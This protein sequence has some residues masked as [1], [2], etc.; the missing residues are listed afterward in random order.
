[1]KKFRD[2]FSKSIGLLLNI[3]LFITAAFFLN[4]KA[5]IFDLKPSPSPLAQTGTSNGQDVLGRYSQEPEIYIYGSDQQYA[6]GGIIPI[7]STDEPAV[8]IG[9]YNISGTA[10]V[11]LYKA[12]TDTLLS[13][14]IHDDKGNQLN[15]SVD[16]N[17]LEFITKVSQELS[18][19]TSSNKV[20]LPLS[21]TGIWYLD[22]TVGSTKVSAFVTRS[23]L[24]VITDEGDNQ[25]VFWGQNY[26]TKRS[27]DSGTISLINLKSGVSIIETTSFDGSGIGY[28]AV[29]ENA[30]IALI[31]QNDDYA[32]IPLNLRYLNYGYTYKAFRISQ[33]ESKYFIFTDRP[34]Y[35]PGDTVYFKAILR[36]DDDARYTIPSG[37]AQVEIYGEYY[38]S[39]SE[40]TPL[41]RNSYPISADGTI[42]GEYKIPTGSKVGYYTIKVDIGDSVYSYESSA[43]FDV[44]YYQKPEYFVEVNSD[45]SDVIA[46]DKIKFTISGSYFSG[47]P[48]TGQKVTYKI[49]S[50]SIFE[51]TYIDDAQHF[52]K[53]DNYYRYGYSSGENDIAEGT[54]TLNKYGVAEVIIDSNVDSNDG[55]SQVFSIE[56]TLSNRGIAPSFAR[57]NV[58]VRSGEY[59][60][61]R[62]ETNYRSKINESYSLPVTIS[63]NDEGAKI[64]GVK[65]SAKIHRENWIRVD[66]PNKKYP[67]YQ[68]EEEDLPDI[69]TKTNDSGVAT[70]SFTPTKVGSYSVTVLGNDSRGNTISKN[71]YLWVTAEDYAYTVNSNETGITLSRDKENYLPG[72]VLRL[73]IYSTIPDR[74]IFLALERGRVQRF[75]IVRLNGKTGTADIPLVETDMPNVYAVAY[76]FS[77]YALDS[78]SVN[79]PVSPNSKRIFVSLV[80]NAE[81]YGPGDTAT[82]EISTK[83]YEGNPISADVAL[84]AVDKAIFE[85]E[86]SNLGD[87]F[88]KFWQER[89][90]STHMAHSLEPITTDQSE[91]GGCFASGT[92]ILM[93]NSQVKDI[94]RVKVGD[95]VLTKDEKNNNL[96]KAKVVGTHSAI[97]DGYLLIN[98]KLKITA[99]HIL[100]VNGS[101][102]EAGNVQIGDKLI[103]KNGQEISI[104]SVE[105]QMGKYKVYNLEIENYH[106]FFA[107]GV[108]VHNQKGDVRTTFKDTA[109]WNPSI[110]TNSSGHA[111]ISFELPDN[112]TTWVIA[113]VADTTDTKVGQ[114]AKD[115]IVAKDLTVRPI[116]PNI[117]R[118]G[119]NLV[120]SALTQNSTEK[121]QSF[122]LNLEFDSGNVQDALKSGV[123]INNSE[124]KQLYWNIQPTK[125]NE[126]G[127]LIFS[128]KSTSNEN[129][130]DTIVLQIPVRA[131]GFIDRNVSTGENEKTYE[132][133]LSSDDDKEKSSVILSLSPT[134]TGVLPL[135]ME[136]LINYPYGCVEQTTSR[137]VPAVIT[138]ANPALFAE[139]LED[140]NVDEII[141]Q[142]IEK[143]SNAQAWDGGWPW[144][145]SG[146]SDPFISAYVV[147]YLLRAQAEGFPVDEHVLSKAKSYFEEVSYYDSKSKKTLIYEGGDR[148]LKNYGMALFGET[149][150]ILKVT[151]YNNLSPDILAIN[152][153]TSYMAGDKDPESNGLNK[154]ISMAQEQGN[155][156]Y[157]DAGNKINFGSKD[158]STALAI[159]AILLAK[160]DTSVA[161]KAARYLTRN[162]QSDYW[163]NTFA[164]AQVLD[165][166]TKYSKVEGGLS[167]NYSYSVELD[168][169][170]IAS[171][172]VTGLSQKIDDIVIPIENIKD[173]GSTLSVLSS[174][175]GIL[176]STLALTEFRTDKNSPAV[177]HGLKIKR[178]Y[179]NEKG[180]GYTLGVGDVVDVV[181]T[182]SGLKAEENYAVI[183]DELPSGIVPIN[184]TLDNEQYG[185]SKND[186]Y[187]YG[188]NVT[189]KDITENGAVLSIYNLGE[190]ERTF[191]YRARVVS[192]GTFIAPPATISLMY[193]P[194]IYGR[195]APQTVQIG[196]G[197]KF[198]PS[199]KY[200]LTK[201]L[202]FASSI[203]FIVGVV[204]FLVLKNKEKIFKKRQN[205]PK[206]NSPDSTPQANTPATPPSTPQAPLNI[207][208]APEQK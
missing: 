45:S 121:S 70:F 7:A 97:V 202:S 193:A 20:T 189:D 166:L 64:S 78:S 68:K 3:S 56:A 134:I 176:Y 196:A 69:S 39:Y 1:M 44:Q 152:V 96:V 37:S 106:T 129:L 55:K 95:T 132:I 117:L 108:W 28:T 35:K 38:S 22:I 122:D 67:S 191:K 29:N 168:G 71:F 157:W 82:I 42:S 144:W 27:L 36:N 87:I 16:T 6:A 185:T 114:I 170:I 179:I 59:G 172:S 73:N 147:E 75:Q 77:S 92:K 86:S 154:L 173:N 104:T 32:I 40:E 89:Y 43:Y 30:D 102:Q 142:S 177:N 99:N 63:P 15:N 150:K 164:T 17:S 34:I 58:L 128:A 148:I 48:L 127:K 49:Y 135:A 12:N 41:Y 119:D 167:P 113:A 118:V 174:G 169:E 2:I 156:V 136:H 206:S 159:Q 124:I 111:K 195:T 26:K 184:E 192:E 201:I 161:T 21:E 94:E 90:N 182:V 188:Y 84:W 187:Y 91:M 140:K 31:Q 160:G 24:G 4:S 18:K 116:L 25:L 141:E 105:W 53:V 207:P 62:N 65:L 123:T 54:V 178:E 163:S 14:L 88:E 11:Y 183:Q 180:S 204:V 198:V 200:I 9:G 13:Y 66:D 19:D 115:I 100:N 51:H 149:T 151:D 83:D 205:P 109:Y 50:S 131:F 175:E 126:A 23:N 80:P 107:N 199:L 33:L 208:K 57:K 153:M 93:G 60:I 143:L 162:R 181:L 137:L 110:H 194:E 158:T 72:D 61:Y 5:P 165:A 76:S 8:K 190:G 79:I 81:K 171:G 101:W 197:S 52:P 47:Q 133:N 103:G 146:N 85:L 120:L 74:D 46:G 130:T 145:F 139:A 98:S 155:G 125:E 186:Y 10:E 138:K 203:I 112:L